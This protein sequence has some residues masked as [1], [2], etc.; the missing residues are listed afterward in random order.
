MILDQ[1]EE[2]FTPGAEAHRDAF[3]ALLLRAA[4]EPGCRV[5]AT[6]RADFQPQVIAHPG[7]CAVLNGGGSYYVGAPGPLALARM[8]EGPAQAVGLAVEPA[9]TA[10]LVSEADREPGGLALL[11]AALQD[12]WL[13]GQDE[14]TLRLDHYARAVGGIKGVLSRRGRRGLA[15]LW[16]QGRAALPRVFGQLIHVDAETGAATRRRVPLDRWPPQGSERRLIEVFSRDAVRLLVCGEQGGQATVEVA[17]EAL[18]REWPRLAV[19]IRTRR[20][21]LIRRDEVRRDAARWDERGRPDHLLPH[22]ELLAE[23]RARLAAAGLWDDLRRE[24]RIAWF[25]AQDDPA[26]LGGLTLEAFRRHGQAGA[27][28]ALPLLA[29]LTRPGRTWETSEAL[30]HW[31]LGQVPELAA[32]LRAGL[33]EVLVLLGHEDALS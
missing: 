24:E 15:L 21:A 9:L 10:Q 4:A 25:L 7:L 20:E 11:A 3:I 23:V 29:D 14:G 19:W 13:A 28:A 26:D 27:L 5:I 31:A 32:W 22:P 1:F 2:V 17:H 30:G 6:L 33:T 8:I 16:P 12:T 18:L